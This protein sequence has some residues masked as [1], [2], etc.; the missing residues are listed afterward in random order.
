M[1]RFLTLLRQAQHD[2]SFGKKNRVISTNPCYLRQP[3]GRQVSFA[4]V[5]V[6]TN[7]LRFD[8]RCIKIW[9][10]K[11]PRW[12]SKKLPVSHYEMLRFLTLLRQAQH[13]I[14]F[15]KK[16]RVISTNPCYL[17][18]PAGRQVSISVYTPTPTL[19]SQLSLHSNVIRNVYHQ[20]LQQWLLYWVVCCRGYVQKVLFHVGL[21]YH[22]IIGKR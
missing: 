22:P 11:K 9:Q 5:R 10:L 17:R 4:L 1:L 2:I 8:I 13:D 7:H 6:F 20:L 19:H 15:G 18:L 12:A 3:A 16:N 14:S 21:H